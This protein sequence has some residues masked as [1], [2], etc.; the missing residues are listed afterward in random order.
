MRMKF[1]K[2]ITLLALFL[3]GLQANAQNVTI[4]PTTGN[5]VAALT[6]GQELGFERGWSS[7]WRHEQLPLTLTVSDEATLTIGGEIA[8]PAGDINKNGN[9]LILAGGEAADMY[10][11][12]SLPKGYSIRGYKIVLL[13]NLNGTTFSQTTTTAQNKTLYETGSDFEYSTII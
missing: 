6:G 5:L 12:L 8:N 1:T 2:L 13:N 7:M 3:I 9:N 4:S 11:V 10:M